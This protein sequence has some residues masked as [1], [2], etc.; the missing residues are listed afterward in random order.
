MYFWCPKSELNLERNLFSFRRHV[1][2]TILQKYTNPKFVSKRFYG[3]SQSCVALH[4]ALKAFPGG[5]N[6]FTHSCV[7]Y[8]DGII[9]HH[10]GI[11]HY[12]FRN[13]TR[14]RDL[15]TLDSL[16]KTTGSV[17]GTMSECTEGFF[18]KSKDI[19][20]NPARRLPKTVAHQPSV[21]SQ[22]LFQSSCNA[23]C[24]RRSQPSSAATT[25]RRKIL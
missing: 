16:K 7:G 3:Q 14:T 25:L 12:F 17:L 23:N 24:Y 15:K 19:T 8:N 22:R 2:G 20:D 5:T 10:Y 1:L 11:A 13:S 4:G 21:F 6:M 9:T 18:M